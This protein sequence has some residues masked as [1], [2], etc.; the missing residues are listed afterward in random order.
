MLTMVKMVC[1]RP[2][3]GDNGVMPEGSVFEIDSRTAEKLEAK[4]TA[5]RWHPPVTE[6]IKALVAHYENKAIGAVENKR[7]R[8]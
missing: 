2:R 6:E 8:K 3:M 1:L 7:K 4:G 5:R